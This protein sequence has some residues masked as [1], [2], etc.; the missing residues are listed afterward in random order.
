MTTPALTEAWAPEWRSRATMPYWGVRPA[1][2]PSRIRWSAAAST[3]TGSA[4]GAAVVVVVVV[5]GA[6]VVVVLAGAVVA[7]GATVIAVGGG[8]A[9]GDADAQ[10]PVSAARAAHHR[11]PAFTGPT[12]PRPRQSSLSMVAT[13]VSSLMMA[14]TGDESRTTNVSSFSRRVSPSTGTLTVFEVSPAAKDSVV[15]GTPV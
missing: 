5:G 6:A 4:T 15:T 13:P 14:P 2:N 1:T 11:R 12:V 3:E 8:S 10:A 9:L 7:G